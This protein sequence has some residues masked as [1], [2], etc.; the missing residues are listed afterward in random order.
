MKLE[1]IGKFI[2][3]MRNEM[4]LTQNQLGELLGGIDRR[5]I[6]KW[7]T[8]KIAPDILLLESIADSLNITVIE[9]LKGEKSINE[10]IEKNNTMDSIKTS[11]EISYKK[12]NRLNN[13]EEAIDSKVTDIGH[14]T[15]EAI[16]FYKNK[17]IKIFISILFII[18][19]IITI[20]V[21][22]LNYY[23]YNII[24]IEGRNEE[25][26][27]SGTLVYNKKDYIVLINN[28][29]YSN[30]YM[31]TDKEINAK[32]LKLSLLNNDDSLV[33][34]EIDENNNQNY[35][36]DLLKNVSISYNSTNEDKKMPLKNLILLIEYT[37]K[38]DIK[39]SITI[40]L[41]G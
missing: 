20:V 28:I 13:N 32:Y 3:E 9:L 29:S 24:N 12:T 8:G 25:F 1:K 16:Q 39:N 22:T 23:R 7:E 35:I 11:D 41:N 6:S 18:I 14:I 27:I 30:I 19:T 21:L 36:N 5:T 10:K 37:D 31:G 15:T 4:N 34:Y 33:S 17:I 38:N 40:P 2:A 26:Y